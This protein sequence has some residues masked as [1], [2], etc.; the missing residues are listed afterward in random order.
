[1]RN[2]RQS[3]YE[4]FQV[5]SDEEYRARYRYEIEQR[6]NRGIT[7]GR[8]IFIAVAMGLAYL[9]LNDLWLRHH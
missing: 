5:F 1:M 7:I 9:Y 3:I 6:W 8:V 2:R 4:M